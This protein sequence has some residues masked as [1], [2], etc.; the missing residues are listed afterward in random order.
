VSEDG[1]LE[2]AYQEVDALTPGSDPLALF[3]GPIVIDQLVYDRAEK[4]LW[5]YEVEGWR[6]IVVMT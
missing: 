5:R 2:L 3:P 6:R 1:F 4:T